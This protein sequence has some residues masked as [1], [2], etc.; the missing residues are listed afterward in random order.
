MP[1][2]RLLLD[3]DGVLIPFPA[4]DGST[5]ATHTRHLVLPTGRAP[6]DPVPIW[7]D[8]SDGRLITQFLAEG[9][10]S[11]AW[12]TSWRR[13]AT[14]VIGPLLG[15][16]DF[17]Y[18]DLPRPRIT[19]SHPAG[20]LWK[21]DFVDQWLRGSA[22]AWIDDDFTELDHLWAAERSAAGHP[23][24]LVQPDPYRGIQP[25]HLAQVRSWAQE[26]H[27]SLR[28]AARRRR[29]GDRQEDRLP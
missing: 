6:S 15:L 27:V 4:T 21:R 9:L 25:V 17:P 16:A 24:L 5:P 19:S 13:D 14:T 22:A 8:P 28:D 12:C 23:T 2:P 18:V 29:V 26:I 10:V 11:P 1:L 7:L 3:V 20:Y